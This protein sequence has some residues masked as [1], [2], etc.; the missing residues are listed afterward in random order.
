LSSKPDCELNPPRDLL[1]NIM[2]TYDPAKAP[3][4]TDW[5]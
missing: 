1:D 3:D 5:L 4:A 2:K